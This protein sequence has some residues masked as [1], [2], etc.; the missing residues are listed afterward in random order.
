MQKLFLET[1]CS[2][3]HVAVMPVNWDKWCPNSN[4]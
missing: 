1:Q 3:L 4:V 2:Y